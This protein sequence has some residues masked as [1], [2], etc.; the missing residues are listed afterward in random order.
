MR[1]ILLL[2]LSISILSFAVGSNIDEK[3]LEKK[4]I[5]NK[6]YLK[7]LFKDT[8][9]FA[10]NTDSGKF[11]LTD[12]YGNHIN[13][14]GTENGIK[15]EGLE[16]KIIFL[17][18]C[19]HVPNAF[20]SL[21]RLQNKYK[22]DLMVISI[23]A[24]HRDLKLYDFVY[25]QGINHIAI[26]YTTPGTV[27]FLRYIVQRASWNTNVPFLI[28]MD[29]N[30]VVQLRDLGLKSYEQYENVYKE[31]KKIPLQNTIN[32]KSLQDTLNIIMDYSKERGVNNNPGKHEKTEAEKR[33]NG[34]S[35]SAKESKNTNRANEEVIKNDFLK[36]KLKYT[37]ENNKVEFAIKVDNH[38]KDAKG[39]VS[40]SFPQFKNDTKI[41][42]KEGIGFLTL[43]AFPAN[44][45]LWSGKY[46]KKIYSDY[47]L[48]EGWNDKWKKNSQKTIFIDIDTT[49]L[50]KL[51]INVRSLLVKNK[52]EFVLPIYGGSDQQ[53]YP[54]K[55][56]VI[57]LQNSGKSIDVKEEKKMIPKKVK[58]RHILVDTKQEAQMIIDTLQNS[59]D[60]KIDF[61][62]LAK[63]YSTGP[64]SSR[65]GDLG[66]FGPDQMVQSFNTAAFVLGIGEISKV[67][68]KTQ[69]GY[70]V[71]YREE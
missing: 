12:V 65:G 38:H 54:V 28:G 57:D 68:V 24:G 56:L 47:L 50:Q 62:K 13:L 29:R 6:A 34:S 21:I 46:K 27:S 66:W 31:L 36:A 11:T 45:K 60:V 17:N 19:T 1:K 5:A 35:K 44:S 43:K 2:L 25:K 70:H 51:V 40:I 9:P 39:G 20:P 69:F 18:L 32:S 3:G 15:V 33:V 37:I 16:N 64:S 67:P 52:N 53:G 55:E 10:N 14:S 4:D 71:I 48:V 7:S 63:K 42:Q 49:G 41:I 58:A 61:I 23:E 59:N 30:H 26:S 8:K 22:D